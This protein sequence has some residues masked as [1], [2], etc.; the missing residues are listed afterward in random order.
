[1][2][3]EHGRRNP[4]A[5]DDEQRIEATARVVATDYESLISVEQLVEYLREA[6]AEM[7]PHFPL[8]AAGFG[9]RA[10]WFE[11]VGCAASAIRIGVRQ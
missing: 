8:I 3:D 10:D 7:E 6:A 4:G 2:H 11:A 9:R 1:M 5:D